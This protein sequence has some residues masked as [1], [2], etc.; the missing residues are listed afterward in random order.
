MILMVNTKGGSGKST[1]AMQL[2]APWILERLGEARVVELDDE[3]HD[4]AS[5]EKSAIDTLRIKVGKDTNAKYAIEKLISETDKGYVIADIGG[6]RTCSMVLEELGKGMYDTYVDLIVVPVSSAGQDV[7]NANKT[8]ATIREKM[9]GYTGK[10]AMVLTRTTTD[11]VDLLRDMLAD[12]FH[13]IE[14]QNLQGP[15]ILPNET[16]FAISR[17]MKM[18]V[19]EIAGQA[20]DLT[21]QLRISIKDARGNPKER[22]QLTTLSRIVTES[23]GVQ[24]HLR[25]Q[26]NELDKIIDIKAAVEKTQK[27]NEAVNA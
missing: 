23:A 9:P 12:A 5:Y 14:D 27:P 17:F 25:T 26:F 15:L 7:I 11:D 20:D 16:C 4:S 21:Q 22:K 24:D 1:T 8:I 18:T 6:N 3:N 2:I 10:I 19:W 13:V